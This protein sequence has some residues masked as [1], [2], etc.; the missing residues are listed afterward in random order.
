MAGSE[1]KPVMVTNEMLKQARLTMDRCLPGWRDYNSGMASLD[2]VVMD[3]FFAAVF[4]AMVN[5]QPKIDKP[6]E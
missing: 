5:A 2:Q 3:G 4:S 1:F 6:A